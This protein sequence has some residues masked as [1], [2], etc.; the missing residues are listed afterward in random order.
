[1]K[2]NPAFTSESSAWHI[3]HIKIKPPRTATAYAGPGKA[4]S[5]INGMGDTAKT[6]ELDRVKEVSNGIDPARE[7]TKYRMD[8]RS[9]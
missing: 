3:W 8:D 1:M 2:V 4:L 7:N 5:Q 6:A 9:S